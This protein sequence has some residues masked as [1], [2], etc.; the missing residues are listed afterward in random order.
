MDSQATD[1]FIKA[2]FEHIRPV[3]AAASFAQK[4]WQI[5]AFCGWVEKTG[6]KLTGINTADIESYLVT[7]SSCAANT[8]RE[9][10][11]TIRDFY[12]FLRARYGREFSGSNPAYEIRFKRIPRRRVV[13]VPGPDAIQ[14]ILER[15][16]GKNDRFSL[17]NRAMAELAYGSGLRQGE[18]VALNVGDIDFEKIQAYIQGKGGHTRMV[19]LTGVSISAI[20]A[21]LDYRGGVS[22]GPLFVSRKDT[23]L[24][25]V[26]V[27]WLFRRK[28]GIRSHI[29]RHACATHMLLN[30]CDVR[31]I[32]EIL[33]HKYLTTTQVYTHI[34]PVDVE[35]VVKSLHPRADTVEND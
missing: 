25:P 19:P 17:R 7:K 9:Y 35:R 23:R 12:S 15:V 8:R 10:L 2:F 14:A 27:S 20:R 34:I 33:G 3:L 13:L 32:Q 24:S 16:S 5:K 28:I 22:E 1:K 26:T 30:G 4:R 11:L 21:Y 29:L 18:L 31:L 6:R